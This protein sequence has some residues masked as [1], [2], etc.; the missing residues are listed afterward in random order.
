L[1]HS[2]AART[3]TTGTRRFHRSRQLGTAERLASRGALLTVWHELL[4]SDLSGTSFS[5][6]A[7][8]I[9]NGAIPA[10]ADIVRVRGKAIDGLFDALDHAETEP[11]KTA[12]TKSLWEATR[13]PSQATF[14][15]G[16]CS[17]LA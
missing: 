1:R 3:T 15:D 9:S 17:T 7:F 2:Q 11:D 4:S 5:A 16:I 8:A 6:D 12:V 13:L 14:S 10:S